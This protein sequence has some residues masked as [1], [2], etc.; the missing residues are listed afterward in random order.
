MEV[1]GKNLEINFLPPK[2]VLA[3]NPTKKTL[4]DWWIEL[5]TRIA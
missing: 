3:T 2:W 4:Q 1:L 5:L